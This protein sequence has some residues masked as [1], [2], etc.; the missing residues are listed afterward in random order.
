MPLRPPPSLTTQV[1][2]I[3]KPQVPS[4]DAIITIRP[5]TSPASG[6]EVANWGLVLRDVGV[7]TR[8]TSSI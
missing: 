7:G 4:V 1:K 2:P 5:K 6:N 3:L 8:I